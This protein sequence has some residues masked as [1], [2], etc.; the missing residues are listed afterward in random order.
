MT[1]AVDLGVAGKDNLFG[2]GRLYL[3]APAEYVM[4]YSIP[5]IP[6]LLLE[7]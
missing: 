7:D 6:L 3:G 5:A 1:N 2:A 4:R